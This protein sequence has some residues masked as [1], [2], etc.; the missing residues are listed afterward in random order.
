MTWQL[1]ETH[2]NG[3][4]SQ[5]LLD[6]RF[7]KETP[8]DDLP[9]LARLSVGSQQ[10]PEGGDWPPEE[11]SAL[12]ALENDLIAFADQFGYGWAVYV[13]RVDSPGLR[14]YD[15]YFGGDA[16]LSKVVPSLTEL[17]PDYRIQWESTSDLG[18]QHYAAWLA[19]MAQG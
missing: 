19:A 11:S 16:D 3:I 12:D 15:F 6:D 17:H 5:V 7:S 8:T 14:E 10:T 2:I 18:W 4:P 13:R 1:F 9:R